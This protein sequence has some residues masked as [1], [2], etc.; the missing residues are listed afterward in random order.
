M[1]R[2]MKLIGSLILALGMLLI[3]SPTVALAGEGDIEIN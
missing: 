2:M 3:I 1:K